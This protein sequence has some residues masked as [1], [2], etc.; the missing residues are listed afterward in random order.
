MS[1]RLCRLAGLWLISLLVISTWS[2]SQSLNSSIGG[3]IKDPSGATIPNA[4]CTLTSVQTN[5]VAKFKSGSSGLY[6]FANIGVGVYVLQVSASG[7]RTY[8]QRGIIVNVNEKLTLDVTLQVG[9]ARQQ[10][11]VTGAAAPINTV[12]GTHSG[13]ITPQVLSNLPLVVSGN[14]RSA[15]SF[16]V[17]MPGVNTGGGGNPFEARINGGLKMGSEA[18]LDGASVQEGL[19]SQ[20][21]MVAIDNDYP[22]SPEAISEVNVVTSNYSPQYGSTTDGVINLVTKAGTDHFHGDL[23]EFMDNTSLNARQWGAPERPKD[24]ENQYG[25]SLGGPA[26]LPILW[27]G[28]NKTYF[29]FN[30]ERWTVRGGSR[31]PVLSIP[32]MK[33]RQGDF[34]DWRDA[35]G[36]LIPVYDPDTTRAN[37]NYDPNSAV[38][39]NNLPYLRDQFMG[40]DGNTP[41]VICPTDPRV[42]SSLASAWFKYLPTPTFSGPL[43]NY[44]SPVPIAD[45]SGAGVDHRTMIDARIDDYL[46]SKDHFNVALHYH[47]T[48]FA[49]VTNLPAQISSDAYL[50]PDGGEIGPW[51]NRFGWDHT[52]TPNLLNSFHYGYMDMRGSEIAVDA[53]YADQLP[54]IPGVASHAQPPS[55]S[56]GSGFETMG[57]YDHHHEDRPTNVFNDTMTWIHGRHTFV[58]GGEYRSLTNN[59]LNDFDASGNFSFASITTGLLG[60]NSGNPIASFLLG[61]VDN[62]S[63]AFNVVQSTYARGKYYSLF[64][65]DTWKLTDKLSLDYGVRWDVGTPASEKHNHL[66]FLD[67]LGANPGAGNRPGRLAFAGTGDGTINYGSAGYG[68][69]F[70]EDTWYGGFGPR[71]GFAYAL[72]QG[73][74]VRGGYGIFLNQAY[75]PGWGGGIAL[76]GFNSTP[77]FSS[78]NGGLTP[79]FLLQQGLPQNFQPPPFIDSSFLN[80]QDGPLYRPV[81][82]NHRAYAQQWNFTIEHQ[83]TNNSYVSLAYVANKGT[84]LPSSETPL[85]AL[86]PSLLSMG[87]SLFDEFQ[88]GQTSLDGVSVPYSGWADQM[89]SCAPSVAQALTPYPQYCG[90]LQ[91]LNENAGTSIY[92]SFQ[93]KA[94]HR[95]S[96]G[97]WFL[98][99]YTLSKLL[100]TSDTV[101]TTSLQGGIQGVISPYQR[102][103]NKVLSENDTPNILA[104]SLI[105]D[106]PFGQG[107]RFLNASGAANKVIGGWQFVTLFRISSGQPYYFRSSQCNVPSQFQ[108]ACIPAVLPGANPFL[109]DPAHFNPDKGPLFDQAAFENPANFNFYLGQGPRISNLRGPGYHNQD[110]SLV[111]N[112]KIT[113]QVGLQFRASFFN[114]WN[115][116]IFNCT[117][118]CFG[119]TAF[120]TD[121]AS[122]AFGQWD[123]SVSDPRRIQFAM[124]LLF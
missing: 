117:T 60:V 93:V 20:S 64:A 35:N 30:Y 47:N 80:G 71:L 33:E 70:P 88:P 11:E 45:I 67:P 124:Q 27:S 86:N 51:S 55:I 16:I 65:G 15:A 108:A 48:V 34:T 73:T 32:S 92:H 113:E 46:G 75:Y 28:R 91:G 100:T 95:L 79:A 13:T 44:V 22:I 38:G 36:N 53:S 109:Q 104:V 4:E 116:H 58:F 39:P 1:L 119:D 14:S 21:G 123:G 99:S 54:Q 37:P 72:R 59:Q 43:N 23:R 115:W 40:C 17:L 57:L 49:N 102:D 98:T 120:D 89:Q 107:K 6:Q 31:F 10:I 87:Q 18:T 19:M 122:P 96:S 7:F 2:W 29:F 69:P 77:G 114:A 24:I 85:N 101:Q 118:R 42:Q 83:F 94:E 12:N 66:S 78:T 84:H 50:L 63:A 106:L 3:V 74:V 52:F 68:K 25:G 26:K 97:L 103:R 62:G 82:A 41:N 8:I 61:E 56:F 9:E 112:T 90:G 121:V 105:Y 111:K 110:I 76:D 81:S 5:S